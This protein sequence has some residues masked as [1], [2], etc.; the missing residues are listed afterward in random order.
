MVQ[1]ILNVTLMQVVKVLGDSEKIPLP[2]FLEEYLEVIRKCYFYSVF[3]LVNS[4]S[5]T[6]LC[7]VVFTFSIVYSWQLINKNGE[8]K[9]EPS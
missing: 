6:V 8:K 1:G 5:M 3:V 4:P 7:L 9:L 2:P